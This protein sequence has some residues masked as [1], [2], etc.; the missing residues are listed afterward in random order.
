MV[1]HVKTGFALA[2]VDDNTDGDWYGAVR[3]A[4]GECLDHA[5]TAG[6][7]V[8]DNKHLFAR[9]EFEISAQCELVI[10]FFKKDVAKAELAGDFLPDHQPTHRGT[11]HGGSTIILEHRQHN[12]GEASDFIHVLADLGALKKVRAMQA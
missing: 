8:F 12:L 2:T 6:D 7:D 11:D 5:A 1:R 4:L 3:S 10:Y 9:R